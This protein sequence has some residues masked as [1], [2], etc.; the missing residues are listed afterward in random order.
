MTAAENRSAAPLNWSVVGSYDIASYLMH[1]EQTPSGVFVGERISSQA[2]CCGGL[3]VQI[4]P[5]AAEEPTLVELIDQ[6]CREIDD[7]SNR[8]AHC[9]DNLEQLLTDVFPD[10]DPQPLEDAD[11]SQPVRFHRP[12]SRTRSIK[13]L[14]LLG[15][16]ELV[17]MLEEDGG[18]E[19]TCHFCNTKY[20]ITA[21]ELEA[22]IE[23]LPSAA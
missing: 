5:K 11:A 17:E 19:L 16:Q 21:Q 20:Q 14:V 9:G 22:L 7:F 4:L 8:L 10:L 12:C 18:A 15:R 6:R 13:A 3:L 23:E 1:S 2:Q